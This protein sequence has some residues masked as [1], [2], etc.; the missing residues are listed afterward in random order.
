MPATG[1]CKQ[2][3]S[4]SAAR[5]GSEPGLAPSGATGAATARGLGGDL[6]G[7]AGPSRDFRG[8]SAVCR[9]LL[10]GG[11]LAGDRTDRGTGAEGPGGSRQE[12]ARVSSAP[13]G[14]KPPPGRRSGL[15]AVPPPSSSS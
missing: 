10:S 1:G 11:W 9:H 4:D 13:G 2:P 12:G 3:V 14:T 7:A 6:R 5:A 15:H 8:G